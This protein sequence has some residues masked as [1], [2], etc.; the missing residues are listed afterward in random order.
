MSV[1]HT[2]QAAE[3]RRKYPDWDDSRIYRHI[4]GLRAI[5]RINEQQRRKQLDDCLK[6]WSEKQ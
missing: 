5:Q 4:E 3:L 1:L 6:F 2:P